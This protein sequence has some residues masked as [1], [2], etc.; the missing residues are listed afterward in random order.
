[1]GLTTTA[2][3]ASEIMD[4]VAQLM[5][6][7]AKT[8]YTYTVQ[9]PYLNM[10]IDEMVESLEQSNSTPTN[11]TSP[12]ITIPVGTNQMLETPKDL[13][14]PV[15]VV[16]YPNNLVEIQEISERAAGSKD[17]FIPLQRREFLQE[18]P[19]SQSLMVWNWE[20]NIIKFNPN[21]A[22]T[23]REVQLKYV[24]HSAVLVV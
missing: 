8:D 11:A 3:T 1:M 16:V 9:I 18:F 21:G 19:I 2:T 5:N 23:P 17:M 13:I 15:G 24:T 22:S 4:R 20:R 7:P 6:D 10:A 14:V 12:P